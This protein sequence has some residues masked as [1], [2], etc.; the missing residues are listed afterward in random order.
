MGKKTLIFLGIVG[1]II[2]FLLCTWLHVR[3]IEQDIATCSQDILNKAGLPQLTAQTQ[4]TGRDV[5]IIG[6][7]ESKQL[8][9]KALKSLQNQCHM[10]GLGNQI[11]IVKAKPTKV[12]HV[13]ILF[14]ENNELVKFVGTTAKETIETNFGFLLDKFKRAQNFNLSINSNKDIIPADYHRYL[15]E[16]LPHLHKI[17]AADI[18]FEGQIITLKGKVASELVKNQISHELQ[19]TLGNDA[20]IVYS[21]I[22]EDN[23]T[24]QSNNIVN[25]QPLN[26]NQ[27][28]QDLSN[29]LK[30]S[31]VQFNS[32][33]AEILAGSFDLLNHLAQTTK[34]CQGVAI[35]IIGHTDK[36]GNEINNIKLSKA[37]ALAVANYLFK[38]GVK[39]DKLTGI[40]VGSSQPIATN[41]TKQGRMQNRRIEFKVHSLNGVKK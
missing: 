17:N 12:A 11:Q 41:E 8:K 37:R 27:C 14:N 6:T 4:N 15:S 16:L 32:G 18:S 10:T 26:A 9:E 20:K 2:I 40:G 39:A 21:L 38:Q 24:Q 34:A 29:L 36:S 23:S 1:F 25:Q 3:S 35:E 22:V 19:N 13:R 30:Q 5:I 7:L 31:K 28:Q 33:S